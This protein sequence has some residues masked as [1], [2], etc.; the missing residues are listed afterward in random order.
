MKGAA[1]DQARVRA[2][3]L[4]G[5]DALGVDA[6]DVLLFQ[7]RQPEGA[8][9]RADGVATLAGELLDYFVACGIDAR[10][11][12]LE[13]GHPDRTFTGRNVAAISRDS[14]FDRRGDFVG[15][16]IDARDAAV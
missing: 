14:H 5:C 10:D 2:L 9:T 11:R 3:L 12:E 8:K 6:P 7:I 13:A 4:G 16:R 15:L 1:Y